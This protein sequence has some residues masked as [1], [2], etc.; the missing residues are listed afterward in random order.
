[1]MPLAPLRLASTALALLFPLQLLDLQFGHSAAL[2]SRIEQL[3][4]REQQLLTVNQQI[5]GR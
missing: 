4:L 5:A 1:M 3:P 2:Q